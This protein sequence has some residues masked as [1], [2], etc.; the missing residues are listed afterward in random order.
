MPR[1]YYTYVIRRE[2]E[3][4]FEIGLY[5][6]SYVYLMYRN[7][8]M[9][10]KRTKRKTCIEKY[11]TK[12]IYYYVIYLATIQAFEPRHLFHIHTYKHKLSNHGMDISN[13][14]TI[15]IIFTSF[16]RNRGLGIVK[17]FRSC[18][19]GFDCSF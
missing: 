8:V 4:N 10:E 12:L 6:T 16:I 13:H 17:N 7:H 15:L 14:H 5:V 3:L 11:R 9:L 19:P 1:M 2:T 18:I